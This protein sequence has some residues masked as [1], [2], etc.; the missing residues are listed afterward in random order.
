MLW[1]ISATGNALVPAPRSST[2]AAAEPAVT[3]DSP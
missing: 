2:W 1:L 3:P